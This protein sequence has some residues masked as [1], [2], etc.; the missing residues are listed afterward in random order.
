MSRPEVD[1]ENPAPYGSVRPGGRTRR[2]TEAIHA[3]VL[4]L[5]EE[6]GTDFT[7]Q[8]IADAAGVSRRTLHRRWADREALVADALE[9]YYRSFTVQ[10]VG[11]LRA[12]L[13]SYLLAFRDFSDSRLER[14][15]NGLAATSAEAHFAH[16]NRR[17][18]EAQEKTL[19]RI[20]AAARERGE[21]REDVSTALITHLLTAPILVSASIVRTP[22]T[23]QQVE[24]ALD[25][26]LDGVRAPADD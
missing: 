3:A 7:M 19:P 6:R 25:A 13:L 1:A 24:A 14:V 17:S 12:D 9:A 21:L 5:L 16:A 2:N 20:L 18:W 26:V 10:T 23:D 8:D 11:D 22:L 15:L 4:S